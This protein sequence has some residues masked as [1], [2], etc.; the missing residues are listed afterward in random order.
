MRGERKEREP[1]GST[2][3][4]QPSDGTHF[5]TPPGQSARHRSRLV[6]NWEMQNSLIVQA[7]VNRP[8]ET[9]GAFLPRGSREGRQKTGRDALLEQPLS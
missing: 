8:R 6:Q 3:P 7:G 2:I 4:D 1:D 9:R 5:V